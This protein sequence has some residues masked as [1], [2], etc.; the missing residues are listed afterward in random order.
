MCL[1]EEKTHRRTIFCTLCS[2]HL[3]ARLETTS[4][5]VLL[6]PVDSLWNCFWQLLSLFTAHCCRKD[7]KVVYFVIKWR[8]LAHGIDFQMAIQII[9]MVLDCRGKISQSWH[10]KPSKWLNWGSLSG[11]EWLNYNY[12]RELIINLTPPVFSYILRKMH[13]KLAAILLKLLAAIYFVLIISVFE[14]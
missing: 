11:K 5:G 3:F 4:G 9:R 10:L 12:D 13:W 1:R 8:K 2:P 14:V 6:M 7:L